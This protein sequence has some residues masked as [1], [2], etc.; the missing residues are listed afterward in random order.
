VRKSFFEAEQAQNSSASMDRSKLSTHLP[1]VNAVFPAES[2]SAKQPF[3][4]R[5]ALDSPPGCGS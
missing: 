5:C 1:F 2:G 3:T 4:G